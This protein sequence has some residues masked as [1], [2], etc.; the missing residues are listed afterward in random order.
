[1]E[2]CVPGNF[3][4]WVAVEL[5]HDL[6]VQRLPLEK[7][8][9]VCVSVCVCVCVCVCVSVCCASVCDVCFCETGKV[10]YCIAHSILDTRSSY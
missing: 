6:T 5:L 7:T 9:C 8:V 4:R 1:M 10:Q 2:G 3:W